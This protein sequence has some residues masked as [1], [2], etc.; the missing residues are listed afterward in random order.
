MADVL[1][2]QDIL[3][4]GRADPGTGSRAQIHLCV[5]RTELGT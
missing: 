5:S 3:V 1:S 2:H 4:P